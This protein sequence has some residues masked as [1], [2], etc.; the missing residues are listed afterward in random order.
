[1]KIL[2]TGTTG[3]LGHALQNQLSNTQGN[4]IIALTRSDMDLSNPDSVRLAI[5]QHQ[6]D[7]I[8]NPA[9]YTAVDKAE[10]E[11]ELAHCVNALSVKAMAHEAFELGI[12]LIHFSTDYVFD[13]DKKDAHGQPFA[14]EEIDSTNPINIYGK[15]KL[16]GEQAIINSGCRHLIFRTSWVYSFFGKNFLLTMLNL[17]KQ[18]DQLNVVNDQWGAPTSADWL[19]S[20]T[21]NIVEQ[22]KLAEDPT[23]WWS[24]HQGLYHMTP[25]G[26]T[27]WQHFAQAIMNEATKHNLLKKTAP[28]IHGIPSIDYPTP[29]KRPF[30]SC[31]NT[32]KLAQHFQLN[33]PT[34]Q[35]LLEE[36][37]TKQTHVA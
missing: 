10:Q 20:N 4:D 8:I 30:N 15:S 2:L 35:T 21:I 22:L 26:K 13:G 7:I 24:T 33:I 16:A 28:I 36:L 34:W 25:T 14:Y 18:R 9:A 31:L 5:Q 27:H 23:L 29:A 12:P 6:P 32:E 11:S 3:Q 17:A 37:F 1:M 19:A